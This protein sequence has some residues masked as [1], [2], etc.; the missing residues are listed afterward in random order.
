[1]P[2]RAILRKTEKR[3]LFRPET[4]P[5]LFLPEPFSDPVA[6]GNGFSFRFPPDAGRKSVSQDRK[7]LGIVR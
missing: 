4:D 1:M 6:G 7:N 5:S 2:I 3:R